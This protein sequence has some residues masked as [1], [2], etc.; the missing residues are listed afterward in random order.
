MTATMEALDGKIA[1]AEEAGN[2][3]CPDADRLDDGDGD[4]D[5]VE[6]GKRDGAVR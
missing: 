5:V 4:V 3:V 1:E 6:P 2:E